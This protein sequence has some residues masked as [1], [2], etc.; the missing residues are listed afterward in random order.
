MNQTVPDMEKEK[1]FCKRC[2]RVLRGSKSS[3]L[4]FGPS[5]YKLWKK[6]HSLQVKLFDVG[7]KNE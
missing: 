1:V 7:D 5:C 6:E 2:G 4:G 3:E